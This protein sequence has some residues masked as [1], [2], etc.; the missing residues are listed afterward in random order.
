[1]LIL[2]NGLSAPKKPAALTRMA[3]GLIEHHRLCYSDTSPEVSLVSG[4]LLTR[5]GCRRMFGFSRGIGN[6]CPFI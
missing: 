1:M 2:I 4:W 5:K 6:F 3:S